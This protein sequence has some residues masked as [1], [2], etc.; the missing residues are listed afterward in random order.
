MA[1]APFKGGGKRGTDV[2][3]Q[4]PIEAAARGDQ[5]RQRAP[6]EGGLAASS[7]GERRVNVGCGWAG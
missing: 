2:V 5:A 7:H 6:A 1:R 4:S 3:T